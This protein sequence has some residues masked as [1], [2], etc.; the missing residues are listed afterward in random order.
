MDNRSTARTFKPS[1]LADGFLLA[2]SAAVALL[3]FWVLYPVLVPATDA[4]SSRSSSSSFSAYVVKPPPPPRVS[5]S[6][7]A[8]TPPSPN[9]AG[10]CTNLRHD[11]PSPTFYDDPAL[12]YTV[13][14][15]VADWDEKRRAWFDQHPSFQ[16]GAAER[17]LMLSGSQPKRCRHPAGDHFLLRAVKNKVD[18]CRLHGIDFFYNTAL[19][20]P[21]MFSFWAK[22]PVVRAAMVAHPETEW[23]WWV[24]SD[25]IVTDMEFSLPL[26]KYAAHNLVV[27][28]WPHLV[29]E[30]KSWTSLN[31]GVFLIRNCQ[32]SMDFLDVWARMGPHSPEY[33]RW[34]QTLRSEF[35]DKGLPES[36]DQSGLVYLLR[37]K[38]RW[39]D[40]I[41]LE[42]DYYFQGYW[43]E[44]VGGLDNATRRYL[45]MERRAPE[46]RRRRAEKVTEAYGAA[47]EERLEAEGWRAGRDGK[48][49]P[50][51][52]HFTGCQPCSGERNQAYAE[53]E[54]WA[55]MERALNFA[56]DQVLRS[57]GFVH[58]D[59]MSSADVRPLPYDFPAAKA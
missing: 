19:L 16:P 29:Y 24:D 41:Y 45:E 23:I 7:P 33:E 32:W 21:R 44:I 17:V 25:A 50:F 54:C 30:K 2:G 4:P 57:Y 31:A 11:P 56:D 1:I 39:A 55:G 15:P 58:P 46:L 26:H 52:T 22:I 36:D 35:K 38:D 51:V 34:G 37:Q 10:G 18:Y 42:S 40:K 20:H 48:R 53:E 59:L 27:H 47:R 28:G 5:C 13:G 9:P 8:T 49:R 12:T 43:V 3:I 14:G 6:S